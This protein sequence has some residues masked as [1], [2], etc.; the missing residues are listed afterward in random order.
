MALVLIA[1]QAGSGK[2]FV[3][4]YLVQKHGYNYITTVTDRK[5]TEKDKINPKTKSVSRHLFES[6][7]QKGIFM[8]KSQ[9]RGHNFGVT[10]T[11]LLASLEEHANNVIVMTPQGVEK[12]RKYLT[13]NDLPH[14]AVYIDNDV[15]DNVHTLT[16][17]YESNSLSR[18]EFI[19]RVTA[20]GK[21]ERH[22]SEQAKK[23][24]VFDIIMEMDDGDYEQTAL[25][26][27]GHV[28]RL[29]LFKARK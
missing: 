12:M 25:I 18:D 22:W 11:K 6:M 21:E 15:F 17:E 4:D 10:R 26:L 3:A 13:A 1:G 2:K 16:S 27:N 5:E 24:N 20:L 19:E 23:S 28:E 9:H 29:N 7:A 8:E 14:V